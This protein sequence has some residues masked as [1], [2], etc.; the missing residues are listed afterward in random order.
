MSL[1]F[2]MCFAVDGGGFVTIYLIAWRFLFDTSKFTL[3]I[4]VVFHCIRYFIQHSSLHLKINL[5][6]IFVTLKS[7]QKRDLQQ[8]KVIL[9][10]CWGQK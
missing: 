3:Y 5:C 2:G 4:F 1:N 6:F 7:Q 10:I 8:K 9:W